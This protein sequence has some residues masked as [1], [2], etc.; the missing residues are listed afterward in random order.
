M[1]RHLWSVR[2]LLLLGS[3]TSVLSLPSSTVLYHNISS[4]TTQSTSVLATFSSDTKLSTIS[5]SASGRNSTSPKCTFVAA[6]H[7]VGGNSSLL[8]G[9][10]PYDNYWPRDSDDK[11]SSEYSSC[12]LSV[13]SAYSSWIQ[14]S[15]NPTAKTVSF[16][17]T[18]PYK[19]VNYRAQPQFTRSYESKVFADPRG[20]MTFTPTGACCLQC[21]IYGG[22]VKIY[23]WPTSAPEPPITKLVNT[24]GFTL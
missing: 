11:R 3:A 19:P 2:T 20:T 13:G 22:D 10:N 12:S 23:H 7:I 4:S 6:H 21:S 15:G 16:V 9:N 17:P 24:K 8:P 18:A 5:S 1:P 14:V